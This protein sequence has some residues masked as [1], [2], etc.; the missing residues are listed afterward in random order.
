MWTLKTLMESAS[1]NQACIN[2][3]WVPARPLNHTKEHY[4]LAGRLVDA[5]EVFMC[6]AEAFTWPEGQ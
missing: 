1:Q 5:W 3:K 2:K 6:R 4:G